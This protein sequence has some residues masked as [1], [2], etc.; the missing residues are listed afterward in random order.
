MGSSRRRAPSAAPS[1]PADSPLAGSP[2]ELPPYWIEFST[3]FLPSLPAGTYTIAVEQTLS[4]GSAPASDLPGKFTAQQTF[5]VTAPEFAIDPSVVATQFPP[6]GSTGTYDQQLPYVIL[7]DPYLPW[8]R[9]LVPG[10][11]L[12]PPTPPWMALLLFAADEIVLDTSGNPLLTLTVAEYLTPTTPDPDVVLPSLPV[13]DI[14]PE[15]LASSCQTILVPALSF[16]DLV[17]Q[18]PDLVSLAHCRT[19]HDPGEDP[20]PV[21]VVLCNRLPLS[22]AATNPPSP[23]AR[24]YAHLVSLEGFA[25]Y[26][27]PAPITVLPPTASVQL[28]SLSNWSFVSLPEQSFDFASLAAGLVSSEAATQGTLALPLEG[29][30]EVPPPSL[31]PEVV[32][33]LAEGY[34]ALDFHAFGAETFAWYRGPFT[35]L[36]PQPLPGL[37]G[38]SGTDE[39]TSSDSLLVYLAG[40]GLFDASYAAAWNIGRALALANGG[41]TQAVLAYRQSAATS[42]VTLAQRLAMP[43]FAGESAVGEVLAHGASRRRFARLL[44]EGLAARWT[45]AVA[46]RGGRRAA[47]PRPAPPRPRPPQRMPERVDLRA[48]LERPDVVTAVAERTGLSP[49]A[50]TETGSA[51]D[52]ITA[53]LTGLSLLD[54]V[55][56]SHLVPDSR[57]LPIESIRFFYVDASWIAALLA[58]A[59]SLGIQSSLDLALHLALWPLL[60]DAVEVRRRG[61]LLRNGAGTAPPAA[62]SAPQSGMLIRSQLI[63]DWPQLTIAVSA[64][65]QAVPIVRDD[66]PAP[67]V[68]L[69]L[70]AGVPDSVTLA[71]PYHSL[72]LG[73][74]AQGVELRVTGG[75]S[76]LIGAPTGSYLPPLAAGPASPFAGFESFLAT[77]CSLRGAGVIDVAALAAAMGGLD[78][79]DF[80]MQ[81]VIAPQQQG[82]V[83]GS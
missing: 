4:G 44:E 18:Q 24:Y 9:S 47:A 10:E 64:G 51:A 80:A 8:E 14:P 78:A 83:G 69:C 31:P 57:M 25:D 74:G 49:T 42:L 70:F 45:N 46:S 27:G 65:G 61:R 67:S 62:T 48:L 72:Q 15:V 1:L 7:T 38:S 52:A 6:D 76:G 63:S 32:T 21:S 54:S 66:D 37:D 3:G 22:P 43:H 16:V 59:A 60:A 40:Q 81:L 30:T 13:A 34:V 41:F 58:G 71:Q 28:V 68:R 53:F 35:T 19:T 82:F 33:R 73:I 77:Y 12:G 56:F 75:T 11:L 55:P 20:G 79:G 5:T 50:S 17:P 2:P 39:P 26:L 29:S 36:P 23:G